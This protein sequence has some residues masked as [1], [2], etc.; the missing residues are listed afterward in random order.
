MGPGYSS[1]L[2]SLTTN[3]S[4]HKQG[5]NNPDCQNNLCKPT[6]C[7]LHLNLHKRN[8]MGWVSGEPF[9]IRMQCVCHQVGVLQRTK[10][11]LQGLRASR[12]R[13]SVLVSKIIEDLNDDGSLPSE[14]IRSV[15]LLNEFFIHCKTAIF[16]PSC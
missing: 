6:Q 7:Q 10:L 11:Q 14:L 4:P 15:R 13:C 2:L 16:S 1:L 12:K 3:I 5:D 8:L 9:I